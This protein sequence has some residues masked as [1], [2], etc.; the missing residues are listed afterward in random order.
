MKNNLFIFYRWLL[1][2][3]ALI[4]LLLSAC[5]INKP[6]T[7]TPIEPDLISETAEKITETTSFTPTFTPKIQPTDPI[8]SPGDRVLI[9]A[10]EFQMGCDPEHNGGYDCDLDELPLHTVYLAAYLIDATEVTNAQ[11]AQCVAAGVCSVPVYSASA[12][13]GFY[14][15]NPEYAN[16]PVI[17]VNWYQAQDYCTWAGGSLPTEAQWEKAARG[18]ADTRAFPWGDASPDCSQANSIALN[19]TDKILCVGGTSAVGSYPAGA[20]PY[21]LLDMAGNVWEW[22]N[23]WYSDT[24]YSTSLDDNPTSP[25]TGIDKVLRGGGWISNEVGSLRVAD[26]NPCYPSFQ[27]LIIGFRC[28]APPGN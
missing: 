22:V 11:Y 7:A 3:I 4:I 21:G 8:A 24:Y 28:A 12:N 10:G 17:Y 18:S 5:S 9:P 14:Y 19:G 16:Y 6:E 20:S 1:P 23:D 26:R 2:S 27:H 13:S 15:G 25:E